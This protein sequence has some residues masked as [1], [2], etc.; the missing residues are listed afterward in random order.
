MASTDGE[1][2]ELKSTGYEIFI[3]ILSI[4]SIVNIVLMYAIDDPNLDTVIEVMNSL[5]SVIFLADFTYRL[6]TARRSPAISSASSVGPTSSPA[7]PS[8]R[9]RSCVFSASC[10][11]S[12]SF[13]LRRHRTSPAA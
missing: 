11:S 10:V 9:R 7:C 5:L 8:S 4:L 2:S 1:R 3:G 13:V 6:F 12:A